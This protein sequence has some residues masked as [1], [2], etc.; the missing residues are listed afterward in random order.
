MTRE[1]TIAGLRVRAATNADLERVRGLVFDVLAEFGLRPDPAGTDADLEDIEA[2]YWKR[3]GLFEL[4]EDEGGR[5]VG[6][7]GLYP[8]D[9]ETCELRKMYFA[10]ELRGRGAGRELLAHTVAEARRLGFKRI[11][12]ETHSILEAAIRLYT[13]FGFQPVKHEHLSPRCDRSF[14]LDLS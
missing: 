9:G 13:R 4:L 12:L 11:K 10:P 5:T 1:P 2:S 8:L 14:Y 7:V 3:G 6:T